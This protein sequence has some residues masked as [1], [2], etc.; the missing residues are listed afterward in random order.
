MYERVCH[1]LMTINWIFLLAIY[2]FF[3]RFTL[4]TKSNENMGNSLL[5]LCVMFVPILRIFLN[6]TKI[7]KQMKIRKEFHSPWIL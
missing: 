3:A 2:F 7:N 4:F 5:I 6:E 1:A